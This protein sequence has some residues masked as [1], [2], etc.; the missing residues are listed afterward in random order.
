MARKFAL[1]QAVMALLF[2]C[3]MSSCQPSCRARE[4]GQTSKNEQGVVAVVNGVT[5]KK[6][7]LSALH[8]RAVEKFIKA[9][10]PM[11]ADLD[12]KLRASILSKMID[13]EIFTQKA[14]QEGVKVDRLERVEGLEKYKEKLGGQFMFKQFLEKEGLT[15]EQV[16]KTILAELNRDKLLSKLTVQEEPSEEEL[17]SHYQANIRAYVQPEMVR[18]RHILLKAS[19]NDPK[20][21]IELVLKKANLVLKEAQAPN[22]SFVD[23]VQKYSEGPSVK[24]GGDLGFFPRGRMVKSFEDLAFSAPL[25]TPVGPVK[26]DFGYHIVYVEEKTSSKPMPLEQVRD[27]IKSAV[28]YNKRAQKGEEL[29]TSLRRTAVI[30]IYD[31]SMTTEDY[32]NLS[33]AVSLNP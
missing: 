12:R 4:S 32:K 17:L 7:E 10:K 31:Y 14:E 23:L 9:N 24:M 33:S 28:K 26:T 16:Q 30:Q 1:V 29:L 6:S 2:S 25:K 13:D 11:S 22:A 3:V 20:E 18:A 15:E 19:P 5:L 27:R 21:K 8:Q